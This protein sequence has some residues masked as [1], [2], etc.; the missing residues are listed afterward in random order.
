[1]AARRNGRSEGFEKLE[2]YVRSARSN[3]R[4]TDGSFVEFWRLLLHYPELLA[5]EKLWTDSKHAIYADIYR[6]VKKAKPNLPVGFHIWHNMSFSPFFRAE[7]DLAELAK[8]ADFFKIV[9]YNNCG[10]P[11]YAEY[12]RNIGSTIFRDVPLQELA[13]LHNEW[14][15]Y[16]SE[17]PLEGLA[18]IGLSSDYVY[19]ETR[20]ALTDV[21]QAGARCSIYPGIDIDIPTSADEKK[22]APEDVHDATTAALSAGAQGVIFSRKYS[23]MRLMNLA[24]GGR[25]V[26]EFSKPAK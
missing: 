15:D 16:P 23:E 19:R 21:S 10:G 5:W 18:T 7:Q 8:T 1:M 17:P 24:A 11:R 20:R 14:L 3:E 2:Q 4:P 12:L 13:R 9:L 25:A 26:R 6:T 22:T